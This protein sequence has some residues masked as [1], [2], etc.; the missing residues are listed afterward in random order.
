MDI[1]RTSDN[2]TVSYQNAPSGIKSSSNPGHTGADYLL[3]HCVLP[4]Q[5]PSLTL[6]TTALIWHG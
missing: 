5:F 4:A 1:G 6:P 3:I 2:I